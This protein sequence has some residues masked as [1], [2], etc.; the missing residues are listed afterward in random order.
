MGSRCVRRLCELGKRTRHL[1]PKSAQSTLSIHPALLF[2][3]YEAP[4][5]RN[6]VA[7]SMRAL[8]LRSLEFGSECCRELNPERDNLL[9]QRRLRPPASG[10]DDQESNAQHDAGEQDPGDVRRSG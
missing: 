1:V 10:G 7:E 8:F 3:A 4:V 6:R 9:L 2:G 5:G